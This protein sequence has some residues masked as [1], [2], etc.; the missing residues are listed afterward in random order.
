MIKRF[1]LKAVL[2]FLLPLMV[3]DLVY[4][5]MPND[6]IWYRKVAPTIDASRLS[7]FV[8]G[9]SRVA[10]AV[11]IHEFESEIRA[12]FG[13]ELQ[14][15]NFGSGYTT[16]AEYALG[17]KRIRELRP[18]VMKNSLWLLEAPGGLPVI[19]TWDEPW[20]HP[21]YKGFLLQVLAVSDFASLSTAKGMAWADRMY[22][23]AATVSPFLQTILETR[24]RLRVVMERTIVKFLERGQ[25]ETLAIDGGVRTDAAGIAL[26]RERTKKEALR[27]LE[28]YSAELPATPDPDQWIARSWARW[29]HESGG[30]A[31]FF[32][33]P[34]SESQT[35]AYGIPWRG[36]LVAEFPKIARQWGA[37]Y[38]RLVRQGNDGGNEGL[39]A[40]DLHFPDDVHLA[41]SHRPAFAR[42]LAEGA[43]NCVRS[44]L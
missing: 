41:L 31:V 23:M 15:F 7:V 12:K 3:L 34:L 17:V 1:L 43:A 26:T 2:G 4:R 40:R 32:E 24:M 35:I 11:G 19:T 6:W 36:D 18:D 5:A 37:C 38:A 21:D 10:A 13:N 20:F 22:F 44:D 9:S 8:V 39:G 28:Q 30:R 33:M 25:S 42:A 29:I 14:I 27:V 16:P